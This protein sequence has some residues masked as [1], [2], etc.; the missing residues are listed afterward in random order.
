LTDPYLLFLFV[1]LLFIL[2][3]GFCPMQMNL[4]LPSCSANCPPLRLSLLLAFAEV[5]QW[6][7]RQHE[8]V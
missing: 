7:V 5:P 4:T 3:V 2:G 6:H 8:E 1:I